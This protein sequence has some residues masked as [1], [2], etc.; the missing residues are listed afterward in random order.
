MIDHLLQQELAEHFREIL[1]IIEP[2]SYG[3]EGLEDTPKRIAKMYA[4]LFR[5]YDPKEAPEVTIFKNGSDGIAYDEMVL[6]EGTF[7]SHCEHHNLPFF[8][9]YYFAYLPAKKGNILGLSKVARVV[10]YFSARLQIQERLG[11]QIVDYLWDKLTVGKNKPVAMG[12]VLRA[13]HMCKSMRGVRK[14]GVMTTSCLRGAL[15]DNPSARDEFLKLINLQ[16][17]L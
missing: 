8:G 13:K 1:K 16:D 15:K 2:E 5:G 14:E 17:P 9:R 6:D 12:L 10:D 11:Q 4:E 3:R 7:H